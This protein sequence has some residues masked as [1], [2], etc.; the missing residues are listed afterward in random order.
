MAR[1]KTDNFHLFF[2]QYPGSPVLEKHVVILVILVIWSRLNLFQYP[3][4]GTSFGNA[5]N[6]GNMIWA[7]SFSTS[8]SLADIR[9]AGNG[10]NIGN[11]GNMV[12][13][14]S[15]SIAKSSAEIR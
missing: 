7:Q 13:T 1:Y 2:S 8:E 15:F 9:N 3:R 4:V 5:G 10:G 6:I 12:R 11:I 14:S